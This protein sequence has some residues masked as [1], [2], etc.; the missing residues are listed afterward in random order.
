MSEVPSFD[1]SHM[2][3][4]LHGGFSD[5]IIRHVFN[6]RSRTIG[7]SRLEISMCIERYRLTLFL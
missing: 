2:V 1:R 6:F 3:D 5:T 7:R 4:A